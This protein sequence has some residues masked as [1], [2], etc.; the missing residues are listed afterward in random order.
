MNN[1][2]IDFIYHIIDW[3]LAIL[4]SIF[5]YINGK[6]IHI[7]AIFVIALLVSFVVYFRLKYKKTN[8]ELKFY[9]ATLNSNY[10]LYGIVNYISKDIPDEYK[11]NKCKLNRL[12]L[13]IRLINEIKK[14]RHN[15]LEVLWI[16]EGINISNENLDKIYQRIGGD[17]S[18]DFKHLKIEAFSCKENNSCCENLKKCDLAINKLCADRN[19]MNV[20]DVPKFS[21]ATFHLLKMEFTTPISPNNEF[22]IKLK[23]CWPQCFNP[24]FDFLLIDP[25]NFAENIQKLNIIV[26]TDGQIL[27]KNS[28]VS[29]NSLN[30]K[31][32][33]H[34]VDGKFEYDNDSQAFI[35]EKALSEQNKIYYVKIITNSED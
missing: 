21:S 12:T 2:S 33:E 31:T 1:K 13:D 15:D 4:L 34:F 23:Y 18:T 26:R 5:S 27:T 8:S 35:F 22:K 28:V 6:T 17:S 14:K 9:K 11:N 24:T 19:K 10:P 29:L 7:L 25:K 32:N 3:T 20:E 30:P 16:H